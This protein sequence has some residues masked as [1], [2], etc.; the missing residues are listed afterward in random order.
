MFRAVFQKNENA[1][2]GLLS[3]LLSLPKSQIKEV[4]IL[5]PIILGET[6][7]DK[8]CILDLHLQLNN[9]ERI[10]IEMQVEDL[11]NWPER[12]I[13]YLGRSFD[14]TKTGSDYSD[15]RTTIH[16]GILDFNLPNLTPE[17]YS[18]YKLMNVKNHEIY[19]DKFV[20]R[21]LNCDYSEPSRMIRKRA[22]NACIREHVF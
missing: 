6:I 18:E 15:I 4:T 1:L 10:N 21:V 2:K 3:A 12:S 5:N 7:D 17:F 14:Q 22:M 20:L 9:N 13:T 16:I 11:G 19:S 8:T